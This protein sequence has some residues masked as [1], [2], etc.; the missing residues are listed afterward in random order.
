MVGNIVDQLENNYI[1]WYSDTEG[2]SMKDI[3]KD[4]IIKSCELYVGLF[5]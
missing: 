4:E 1:I 3:F 5:Y 2:A